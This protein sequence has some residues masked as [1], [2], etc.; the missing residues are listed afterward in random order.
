M[1]QKRAHDIS[2][3]A[4]DKLYNFTLGVRPAE[5]GTT[6]GSIELGIGK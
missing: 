1:F 5:P 2:D 4:A 6:A 3:V